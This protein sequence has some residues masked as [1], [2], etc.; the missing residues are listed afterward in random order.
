MT[1]TLVALLLVAA[2]VAQLPA[3]VLPP[4]EGA[5]VVRIE[6]SGGFTGRGS[7]SFTAS[8]AGELLC[9]SAEACLSRL[10]PEAQQSIGRLVA[11]IPV[12]RDASPRSP[13]VNSG[14][15][16]DCVTTTMTVQRRNGDAERTIQ[17]GWDEST[18][19]S[20]PGEVLRLH[21]AVIA[22]ARLR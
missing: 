18:V 5:W 8:S 1:E 6:T 16:S 10:V 2:Q 19:G 3:L 4:G 15:C 11:G 9:T 14:I 17:F 12:S 20:I 7:G 21:S 22:L 13:V